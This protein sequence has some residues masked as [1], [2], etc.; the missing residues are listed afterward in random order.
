MGQPWFSCIMSSRSHKAVLK[1]FG[2]ALFSS[3][4]SSKKESVL[5]YIQITGRILIHAAVYWNTQTYLL[6]A[7]LGP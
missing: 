3:K 5:K 2:C 4:G 1:F 7:H 6:E